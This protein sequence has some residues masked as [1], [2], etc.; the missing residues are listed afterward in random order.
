M[1]VEIS[2]EYSA[3][4]II[5]PCFSFRRYT[6]TSTLCFTVPSKQR[7]EK[8]S[9]AN[10]FCN[11]TIITFDFLFTFSSSGKFVIAAAVCLTGVGFYISSMEGSSLFPSSW[12]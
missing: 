9:S 5:I 1:L 6:Q 12:P 11:M 2:S 4:K 10:I 3:T 7:Q 8:K